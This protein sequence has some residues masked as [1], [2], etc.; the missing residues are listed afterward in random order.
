MEDSGDADHEYAA[1]PLPSTAAAGAGFTWW[2][3]VTIV[4]IAILGAAV[5]LAALLPFGTVDQFPVDYDE[6]VYSAAASLFAHG[7]L[8]YRDFFFVH[9]PGVL[10]V[11][12]PLGGLSPHSALVAARFVMVAVGTACIVLVGLIAYRRWGLLAAST[13]R[14]TAASGGLR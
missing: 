4:G 11:L 5:R 14:T 7:Q 10:Y 3:V 2:A 6:G 1:V 13:H 9:P 8:P 12:L